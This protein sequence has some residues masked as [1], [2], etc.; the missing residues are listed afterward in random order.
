[1]SR[2]VEVLREIEAG[3]EGE[4]NAAGPLERLG[5]REGVGA[6]LTTLARVIAGLEVPS[7]V[8]QEVA[9]EC[10]KALAP[11]DVPGEPNTLWALVLKAMRRIGELETRGRALTAALE[12]MQW[13]RSCA[14]GPWEQCDEGRKAYRLVN[15]H[16]SW[17]R[18]P[19][20]TGICISDPSEVDRGE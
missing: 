3:I 20:H 18:A 8:P 17:C 16:K 19:E 6:W 2:V 11:L 14:E 10:L 12:H 7:Y 4:W 5:E 9:A 13:C 15:P 1:M